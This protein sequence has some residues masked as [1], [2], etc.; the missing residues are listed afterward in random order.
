MQGSGIGGSSQGRKST[1]LI[2]VATR[3]RRRGR[4]REGETE[5][6]GVCER[7]RETVRLFTA[8]HNH[9]VSITS[10]PRYDAHPVGVAVMCE[11]NHGGHAAETF[12][13]TRMWILLKTTTTIP[14]RSTWG[15]ATSRLGPSLSFTDE[16]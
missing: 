3:G 9:Q 8:G 12:R 2:K 5:R 16:L 1:D 14:H 4:G 11:A 10:C 15:H 7:E 13:P 6:R